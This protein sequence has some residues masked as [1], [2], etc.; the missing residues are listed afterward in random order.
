MK[1]VVSLAILW[2]WLISLHAVEKKIPLDSGISPDNKYEVF[3]VVEEDGNGKCEKYEYVL[4]NLP[5]GRR[6][7]TVPCSYQPNAALLTEYSL[8]LA[9]AAEIYWSHDGTKLAIDEDN[10]RFMGTVRIIDSINRHP[11][12]LAL[13]E[14]QMDA[15]VGNKLMRYR[16]RVE[17]GWDR[18]NQRLSLAVGGELKTSSGSIKKVQRSFNVRV[19]NGN[20]Y[21]E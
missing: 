14:T 19:G 11:V 7:L 15:L 12:W 4:V 20:L 3:L 1:I 2:S 13:A 21:I 6:I 16:I 5:E 18:D 9:K 8:N 10:Y 17:K